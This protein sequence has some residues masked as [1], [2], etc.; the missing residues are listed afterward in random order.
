M[1]KVDPGLHHVRFPYK[2]KLAINQNLTFGGR[3]GKIVL[4]KIPKFCQTI[5]KFLNM[6]T[7]LEKIQENFGKKNNKKIE[8]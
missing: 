6:V 4:S 5:K 3:A 1:Q 2:W 7:N 8:I